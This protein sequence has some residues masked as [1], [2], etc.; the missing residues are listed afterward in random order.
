MRV[1]KSEEGDKFHV[2]TE[3]G[4]YTEHHYA[5]EKELEQLVVA[6][7]EEVFGKNT[8]YVDVKQK[9]ASKFQAR[10][11][12]GLLLD[13]RKKPIPHLWVVE[14][15]LGSHDLE[16]HVVPQLRGFVKAFS[17]EETIATVRDSV[18]NEIN[19]D[20]KKQKLFKELTGDKLEP[21]L[22]LN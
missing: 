6:H 19:T 11:T 21:Y 2:L 5:N 14:Y 22:T 20:A 15:E 1:E 16:R 18:Y 3:S 4:T 7:A 13:F 12:D 10:I 17:N 9:I 8:L